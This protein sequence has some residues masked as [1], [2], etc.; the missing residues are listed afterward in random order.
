MTEAQ[1]DPRAQFPEFYSN[2][3]VQALADQPRWTVSDNEKV[4][5]NMRELMETGRIWGAHETDDTCLVTLDELTSFLPAAANNAFYLH[6][7][8]DG[9]L[10]LDIE[11]TCP[12]DV[13]ARLVAMPSVYAE[14]SMSGLGWHLVM[15]LPSNFW[16]YPIATSK[17][18]LKQEQ[19]HYEI[20]LDHWVTFTRNVV[21]HVDAG[22]GSPAMLAWEAL[23]AELASAAVETPVVEFEVAVATPD[24]PRVDQIVGLLTRPGLDKTAADFGGD[25]SRFEFSTLGTLYNRLTNILQAVRDVERDAVYDEPVQAWFVY[26]AA[27]RLLPHR[28]K[29]DEIRS[30]VPLLL[31]SA[32]ALVGR[33]VADEARKK[34]QS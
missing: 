28:D 1:L 7:Q 31:S 12:P 9:V 3:V 26:E 18:V 16:Q 6:A 15:P 32:Q 34:E 27:T 22:P 13:A 11:K 23:Y 8:S 2:P 4:P 30:G 21:P 5:I 17:R 33:R 14:R 24:V 20:L 19:G 10:V 29:H 25:D